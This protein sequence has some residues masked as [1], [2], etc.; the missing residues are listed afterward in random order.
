MN[1]PVAYS[2]TRNGTLKG[3][4]W[5]RA[6]ALPVDLHFRT[7]DH[8]GFVWRVLV[9]EQWRKLPPAERVDLKED[10]F[11]IRDGDITYAL[12]YT[13]TPGSL[14]V[15]AEITNRGTTAF[16][17]EILRLTIGVDAE[18]VRYPQWR[19][20]LFPTLLRCEKTHFWGYFMRP[21]GIILGLASRDP[22]A[23]WQNLYNRGGHR[24]F[25]SAL[26]LMNQN[27]QPQRHPQGKEVLAPGASRQWV[28][29]L[30]PMDSLED[31]QPALSRV[32]GIPMI[33][34]DQPTVEE[35]H[36]IAGRL[37]SPDP[38]GSL[39]VV[40]P[41]GKRVDCVQDDG[42]FLFRPPE[43]GVYTITVR[44]DSGKVAEAKAACRKPWSWYSRQARINAVR[45]PQKAGSHTESWYGLF[46]GYIARLHFPD[47][48]LDADIDAKFQELAPLMY[49]LNEMKPLTTGPAREHLHRIQNHACWASLL[50]DRYI[51]TGD[52]KSLE[53]AASIADFLIICQSEDGAY[54]NGNNH[55]TSVIYL[56]KSMMEVMQEDAKLAPTDTAWKERLDR[57][58]ASVKLAIDEL[59]RN[60]DNIGT[61]GEATYEDGMIACSYTQLALYA[62]LQNDSDARR[63]Y[64]AA[65]R[66]L[67]S[68]H[69]CL[70]QI[71]VP[72]CRMNGGSLRYW[73]SQYDILT[74]NVNMM[75]SPHGWSAWRLYGLWYLYLLTGEGEYLRQTM[76]GLGACVQLIDF[77][78]GLLRW[79]FVPDPCVHTE[80][81]EEDPARP[82]HGRH[83]PRIVGEQYL[84]MISS[85]FRAK[86]DTWVFGYS[87]GSVLGGCCDNDVHEIFK[88]LGE[89]ALDSAYVIGN[90][91]GSLATWNCS[92]VRDA[93]GTI[94]VKPAEAVVSR[95][96]FNL[97]ESASVSVAFGS[98]RNTGVVEP[99]QWF[100]GARVVRTE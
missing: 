78:S 16:S 37:L 50:V 81:F 87:D 89:I 73:E 9:D 34:L 76:N 36:A 21:D 46:S 3:M 42:V 40:G 75:N 93:A 57:H 94:Q 23:S 26:D 11:V 83:V 6:D 47:A 5:R 17:P 43:A 31:V 71:L 15:T 69:R 4:T 91:D 51:A 68:G 35:G 44:T 88:C 49:D 59:E 56:A 98:G 72:D 92:A 64:T 29:H 45:K 13:P 10:R 85:W 22:I 41:S 2:L 12:T 19:E 20:R 8:A 99:M 95:V 77:D 100:H 82:G 24:I 30:V 65:A 27:P 52:I 53:F 55:Y 66:K 61:E 63:K 90:S 54:R 86:P 62:L 80:L 96:H 74:T 60:L 48:E 1:T 70:S 28:L 25:S 18:M 7:D 39:A 67:A 33:V 32:A 84:P 97:S 58:A 79:A 38:I 14:K